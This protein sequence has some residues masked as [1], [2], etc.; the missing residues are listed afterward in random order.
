MS[1][2]A[3]IMLIGACGA[4]KRTLMKALLGADLAVHQ[5]MA[6]TYCGPFVHT[7]GE[8]LEN[9][10]FYRSL[11]TAASGCTALWFLQDA[12]A[13]CSLFPPLLARTFNVPVLGLVTKID[14]PLAD[15]ARA[16]RLLQ[17]AGLSSFWSV[18]AL[19][20]VGLDVLRNVLA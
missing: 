16:E 13:R 20:G 7:P 14:A 2:M 4:G 15:A 3:R 5:P 10:R 1:T 6:V 17:P 8:F 18:S 19:N 9:R 11:I 12:T